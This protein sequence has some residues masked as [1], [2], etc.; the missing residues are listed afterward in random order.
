MQMSVFRKIGLTEGEIRVYLSLIKL[1][2]SSTG[3]IMEESGISSSKVYLIL[4]KLV[5][6]GFVSFV[7]ENNVKFFFSSIPLQILEYIDKKQKEIEET[8]KEAKNLVRELAAS[9]GSCKA[10]TAR[11]Y[12]GFKGMRAAFQNILDELKKGE[13]FLFFG[14]SEFQQ[15]M[16]VRFFKNLHTQ[17]TERGIVTKGIIDSSC[18]SIYKKGFRNHKNLKLKFVKISLPHALALGKERVIL[19]LWD[20]NPIAFEILSQRLTDRYRIYFNRVW[21][22]Q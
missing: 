18:E 5:K 16:V 3:K 10:E 15:E 2:K 20:E 22:K 21:E 13:E 19:T 8:K 7:S 4:E 11:I 9:L 6:K 1:N 12:K 14:T 17:R